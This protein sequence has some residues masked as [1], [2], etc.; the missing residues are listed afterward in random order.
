LENYIQL[1]RVAPATTGENTKT[2]H[3]K[4]FQQT[5]K[6]FM[7]IFLRHGS[8]GRICLVRSGSQAKLRSSSSV[9]DAR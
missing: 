9:D 5:A 1:R 3:F 2:L 8:R 6:W 4:V 7:D